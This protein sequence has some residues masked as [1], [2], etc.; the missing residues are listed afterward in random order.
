MVHIHNEK[1]EV[2]YHSLTAPDKNRCG[3]ALDFAYLEKEGWF[4]GIVADGVGTHPCDW[5]V[6]RLTCDSILHFLN[7]QLKLSSDP[8]DWL[9]QAVDY[10]Q[11]QVISEKGSCKGMMAVT[12]LVTWDVHSDKAFL[13]NIGDTRIYYANADQFK[14]CTKDDTQMVALMRGK[15][16]A[17]NKHGQPLSARGLTKTIG[18]SGNLSVNVQQI[19][20]LPGTAFLLFSDGAHGYGQL[21]E[22]W[23]E[24]IFKGNLESKIKYVISQARQFTGDDSSILIIRRKDW[25]KEQ[26]QIYETLP[27]SLPDFKAEKLL[28]HLVVNSVLHALEKSIEVG[29]HG[30]TNQYLDYFEHYQLFPSR[31]QLI[32]LMDMLAQSASPD[33]GIMHRLRRLVYKV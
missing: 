23:Y 12:A 2:F 15:K 31:N 4:I 10:A 17:F 3:D 1:F 20:F 18:Q 6:S 5:K 33:A 30:L 13:I 8:M 16:R 28:P 21:N 29:K 22:L 32:R 7:D 9:I 27:E 11:Q 25:P 26:V 14:L 19:D 24:W